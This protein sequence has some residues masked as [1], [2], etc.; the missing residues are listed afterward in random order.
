[1]TRTKLPK[2]VLD[3]PSARLDQIGG[4]GMDL[5]P[6]IVGNPDMRRTTHAVMGYEFELIENDADFHPDTFE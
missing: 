4:G 5:S 3:G 1:M 6:A 2:V